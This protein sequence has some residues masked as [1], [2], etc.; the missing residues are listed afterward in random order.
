MKIPEL[1]EN[2][3]R[4]GIREL[5]GLALQIKDAIHLE[6]GEPHF[7]TPPSILE[8]LADFYW[9]GEIKYTPTAG[10]ASL[11]RKIAEKFSREKNWPIS[12]EQV[13]V[14]P[15]SLFGTVVAFRA[16]LDHG[17]EALLPD[18]GFTN[19]FAQAILCGATLKRYALL[20]ENSFLPDLASI[21]R[22][23]SS[24]TRMILVNS[25]S[26]PIGV[27]FDESTASEIAKLAEELDLIV[28]ADEAYEKF[29]YQG[30]YTGMHRFV[31][32]E[33]LISLFSFSKTYALSGWRIGCMVAPVKLVPALSK[34]AEYLIACSS[35]ISQKAAEIALDLPE[36]EVKKMRDYYASNVEIACQLLEEGE[37]KFFRPQ[38]G[39][40]VW[41]DVREYGMPSLEF[42][43]QLL[44]EEKVALAPGET[45]GE[46]GEGFVRISICRTHQE[47]EE[48]VK[49]LVRF[50]RRR[51]S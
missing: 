8:K 5:M 48:G 13:I 20:P 27:T 17:E 19:H 41:V 30:N 23:A 6:I 4:S 22:M 46:N 28:I 29:I 50:A 16:L 24:R 18:P 43:K 33:R 1:I 14:L 34:V 2:L 49:R 35:H 25:P 11:R 12:E 7:P 3:P 45:F 26:N 40:Y 21:R 42:C 44:A 37:M 31:N 47:V 36:E 39:Y 32:P 9:K 51:A 15:G 10:I 38:G